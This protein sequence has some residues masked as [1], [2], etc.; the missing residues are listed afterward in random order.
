MFLVEFCNHHYSRN[1]EFVGV[2]PGLFS[3]NFY[4]LYSVNYDQRTIRH[5]QGWSRVGNKCGIA[6]RVNKIYFDIPMFQMSDCGIESD[7]ASD[8]IF[9]VIRNGSSFFNLT[10]ARRGSG[11]VEN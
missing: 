3:L 11:D 4:T 1:N 10:P 2:G 7:L 9:F 6:W 5:F 8:G